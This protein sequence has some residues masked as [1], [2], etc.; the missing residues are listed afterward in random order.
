M[1]SSFDKAMKLSNFHARSFL[2][3][4]L[5]LAMTAAAGG[6]TNQPISSCDQ[7]AEWNKEQEPFR[8]YGNTYYVGPHGLSSVLITSPEG[9][10]LLDGALSESVSQIVA[11]IRSLGFRIEDVKLIVNSHVHYDHAGGIAGLQRLSGAKVAASPWSV[12]VMTKSGVSPAD[13]QFGLIRPIDRIDRVSTLHD[14]QVFRIGN[15]TLTAH[16]TPGH[17][18]GGTS[19]TWQSCQDGHCVNLVYADSMTSV[20]ADD[21]RFSDSPKY[22]HAVKDFEKSFA[23]LRAAPCD[24]L[25]TTHP[26]ASGLWNRVEDRRRGVQPD[27]MVATNACKELAERSAEQLR[28]RLA[29][30]A[31]ESAK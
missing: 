12:E 7:C 4:V 10:V 9:H 29:A 24:I 25:L 19:W 15:I 22:P 31:K 13:P 3:S 26:D 11:H 8:I 18:Q 30:E 23:F 21:F 14:G 20:S 27:P 2:L 1:V 28:R 6:Q 5:L 16:L 17:T